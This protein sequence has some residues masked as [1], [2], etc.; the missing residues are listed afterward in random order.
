MKKFILILSAL[1][2]VFSLSACSNMENTN[3]GS[4]ITNDDTVRLGL[5]ITANQKSS[6]SASDTDGAGQTNCTVAAVL[7]D[8]AGKIIKCVIDEI[9]VKTTFSASG[10]ITSDLSYQ[11][12]TK[13][14]L[15]DSYDMKQASSIGKEWY[16][17]VKSFC[18]YVTGKS[19]KEIENI[20]VDKNQYP[21]SSDLKAS[22]TIAIGNFKAAIK[23]AYE[24]AE[25]SG[26]K[27]DDSLG[28]GIVSSVENSKDASQDTGA[29]QADITVTAVT[30]GE[31]GDVSASK[32]DEVRSIINFDNTGKITSDIAS[33]LKTK[34]ELGDDYGMKKAS[35]IGKEW[36]EQA[37][38]LEKLLK[39]K[40]ITDIKDIALDDSKKATASDIKAEVTIAIDKIKHAFTKAGTK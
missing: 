22:V 33:Q 4:D 8:D 34:N 38:S 2:F 10:T 7:I 20:S 40:T 28:L 21:T 31:A 32:I 30:Y 19:L 15:K 14:E 16:E 3:T 36:Y 25:N 26:S 5:G 27:R 37:L 29:V 39:G 1:V 11:A 6:M 12:K 17:Q 35:S 23:K 24:N 13:N 9:E 18:E